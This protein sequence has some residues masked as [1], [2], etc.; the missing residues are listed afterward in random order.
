MARRLLAGIA[1]AASLG[2]AGA[3][4]AG[5]PPLVR[6]V[7]VVH[8]H[9]VLELTVGA[10]RPVEFTAAKRRAVDADRALLQGNV[11]LRET[12]RF[13]AT[14]SGVVRWQSPRALRPG[15]YFV[16]V[17]AVETEGVGATDC[18]PRQLD[19]NVRWSGLHRVLIK[20]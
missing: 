3:A 14:A 7:G 20:K 6:S 18:P 5:P 2:A 12:I 13:P 4:A 9:V 1:I 17:K 15:R 8:R 16:Q 10:V 19:C 11:R